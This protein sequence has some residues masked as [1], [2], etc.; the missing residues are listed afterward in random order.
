MMNRNGQDES[1]DLNPLYVILLGGACWLFATIVK[2]WEILL[3]VVVVVVVVAWSRANSG[4]ED[5]E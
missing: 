2:H 4:G 5:E 1:A 3:L